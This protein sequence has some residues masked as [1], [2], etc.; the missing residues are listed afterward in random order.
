MIDNKMLRELAIQLEAAHYGE[1]LTILMN[2]CKRHGHPFLLAAQTS[3][4]TEPFPEPPAKP[5]DDDWIHSQMKSK[6]DVAG[7][8]NN[9]IRKYFGK[10]AWDVLDIFHYLA[11]TIFVIGLVFGWWRV[12]FL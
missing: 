4:G 9:R 12:V 6:A 2:W 3:D 10:I 5:T 8:C 7:E 11:A 1:R